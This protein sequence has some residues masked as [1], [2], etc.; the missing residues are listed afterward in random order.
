MPYDSRKSKSIQIS[1]ETDAKL[2][3]VKAK[4]KKTL[5]ITLKSRDQII[6]MLADSYLLD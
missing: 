2:M 5:H 6:D 4:V 1:I 3:T